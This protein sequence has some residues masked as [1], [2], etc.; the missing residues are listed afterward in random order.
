[1]GL[2]EPVKR[3]VDFYRPLRDLSDSRVEP[4]VETVG[5]YHAVPSGPS[6]LPFRRLSSL[7]LP[8]DSSRL[9]DSGRA[10]DRNV[11]GTADWKV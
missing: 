9:E 5:Y 6:G 10:A 2:L 7:R 11:G 4:A 3:S 8:D 1:M